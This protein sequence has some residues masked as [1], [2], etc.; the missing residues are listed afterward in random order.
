[1]AG[2]LSG[3]AQELGKQL[4]D[5]RA[6][7]A[8]APL[9]NSVYGGAQP[10]QQQG[11][12]SW[13]Q[14]VFGGGQQPV[15]APAGP[16]PQPIGAGGV[17]SDAVASAK[18]Q[19]SFALPAPGAGSGGVGGPV[20]GVGAGEP[21]AGQRF[22]REQLLQLIGNPETRDLGKAI[23][24]NGGT[25]PQQKSTQTDDLQ[26]YLY[27]KKQGFP[28]TFVEYQTRLKQAGATKNVN[29]VYNPS[30]G[31]NAF[32]KAT[33]EQQAKELGDIIAAGDSAQRTIGDVQALRDIGAR[34]G[35][36]KAAEVKAL[37]GPWAKAA[38]IDVANL[39][40][41]EAYNAISARQAQNFRRPGTG[42]TSDFDVTQF[43]RQAMTVGK[44]PEGNKLIGDTLQGIAEYDRKRAGI[45]RQM[46]NR[47]ITRAEGERQMQALP[48]PLAG[49][50]S[51][52]AGMQEDIAPIGGKKDLP[53]I[54]NPA[55]AMK[56]PS[57]THF[58]DADGNER[59]RP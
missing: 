46:R 5:R 26:E 58:F 56:L 44:T 1:M 50:R 48:D 24:L 38:G 39:G 23:L 52:T 34:I 35:T 11:M 21:A 40:D 55:D 6:A 16:A 18:P 28:G 33:A 36:G 37:L 3:L 13:L 19:A 17:G 53:R 51:A 30:L 57:G 42:A 8:Y 12:G 41:I 4:D 15:A 45:A 25:L 9:I 20:G 14:N 10:A 59:I 27:A 7:D 2:L 54:A 31:E 49:W 22:D 32:D 43:L 47:D 29:N